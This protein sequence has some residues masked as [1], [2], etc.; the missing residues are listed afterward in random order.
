MAEKKGCTNAQIA[1]GWVVAISKAEG[2]P[3]IV[4]IPG[5]TTAER[6]RENAKAAE[7]TEQDIEEINGILS[8]CVVKGERYPVPFMKY[9][10]G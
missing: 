6:V 2:M 1:I 9:L 3:R 7:L 8:Q 5:A 10:N 4:P